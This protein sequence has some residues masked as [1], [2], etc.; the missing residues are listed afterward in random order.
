MG[1]VDKLRHD[2]LA[3]KRLNTIRRRVLFIVGLALF[4]FVLFYFLLPMWRG[5]PQP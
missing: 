5:T 1:I 4:L 2:D 3:S